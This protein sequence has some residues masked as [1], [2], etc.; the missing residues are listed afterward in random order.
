MM[1][2]LRYSHI[3]NVM[4]SA[5]LLNIDQLPPLTTRETH[6]R[7]SL[8][9]ALHNISPLDY[10]FGHVLVIAKVAVGIFLNINGAVS[11]GLLV[12]LVVSSCAGIIVIAS[13][14]ATASAPIGGIGCRGVYDV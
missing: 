4:T 7:R 6:G 5:V 14:L 10:R 3:Q 11:A 13:T 9:A 2:Q 1:T 8:D 12:I